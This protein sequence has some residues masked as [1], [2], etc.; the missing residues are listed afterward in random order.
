MENLMVKTTDFA[1]FIVSGYLHN[2][3]VAV[4]A[5]A[6][7]GH[8][9]LALAEMAGPD[10]KV[11]AFDI[12]EKA[13]E[14]THNLLTQAGVRARC[15][16]H[17]ASHDQMD[18]LLP[19]SL[20]GTVSVVIFN[21]G[22]LPGSEKEMTTKRETTLSAVEKSLDLIRTNGLVA[23]TMYSGH[24]QGLQEKQA[25]L[26]FAAQLPAKDFHVAYTSYINQH[27][28]PPELLCITKK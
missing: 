13:L 7:N 4:D 2:G 22:Y 14:T 19:P 3:D 8:D 17:H 27:K 1:L 16:L 18:Q 12:Q 10:G 23:I 6:G 24:P 15:V 26:A 20:K 5:T 11:Y 21:L 9:T 25:L 28:N